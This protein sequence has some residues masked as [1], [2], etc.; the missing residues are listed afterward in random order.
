MKYTK[1]YDPNK[2]V[3]NP[4][5]DKGIK[6]LNGRLFTGTNG[7]T[8]FI[9]AAGYR[10][11]SDISDV[12]SNCILWSSSL[13]LD[14]PNYACNL[15]FNSDNIGIYYDDRYSGFNVRPVINL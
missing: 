12:G 11:D 3:H 5:D 8:L 1:N 10:N 4:K 13:N 14:D 15:Y 7:N 2:L 9:P 6:G